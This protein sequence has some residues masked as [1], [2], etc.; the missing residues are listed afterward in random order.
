MTD[1]QDMA[2]DW[3]DFGETLK[4]IRKTRG[5]T[6]VDLAETLGVSQAGIS[7][8][9][10]G[11]PTTTTMLEA[12]CQALGLDLHVRVTERGQ[13]LDLLSSMPGAV[14]LIAAMG[15]LPPQ[16]RQVIL[17]AMKAMPSWPEALRMGLLDQL[18]LY[19]DRYPPSSTRRKSATGGQQP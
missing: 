4:R 13:T 9:E 19:T 10:R 15:V 5:I 16:H 2:T 11:Y 18:Q 14:E 12:T 3:E 6:Q 8:I 7:K 17:E 1:T